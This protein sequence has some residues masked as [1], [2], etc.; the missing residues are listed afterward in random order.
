MNLRI[1]RSFVVILVI[2]ILSACTTTNEVVFVTKSSLSIAEIETTPAE[3]SVGYSRVE[4][5]LAP[6]YENGALPPVVSSIRSDGTLFSPKIQQ[7]YATGAAANLLASSSSTYDYTNDR[8]EALIGEKKGMFFGTSTN[9]GFKVGL[10]RNNPSINIGYKRIEASY[11]PLGSSG[12]GGAK[13]DVYPSVIASIDT[14]IPATTAVDSN[15]DGLQVG[16]YFATGTAAKIMATKR[17]VQAAF[18]EKAE[19]A[20]AKYR[21][22]LTKQNQS[23]LHTLKC[24]A[25]LNDDKWP[26]VLE[27]AKASKLLIGLESVITQKWQAYESNKTAAN[28]Q[29]AIKLYYAGIADVDGSQS[30]YSAVLEAHRTLVCSLA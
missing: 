25:F 16:Q 28:R 23:A 3:V 30:T 9:L 20:I 8:A 18:E 2:G 29:E 19:S 22:E 27:A 4:G 11:I 7:L 1:N 17:R 24:A 14:T 15:P 21:Q 5:Y 6:A 12:E 26:Q 13:V 10:T